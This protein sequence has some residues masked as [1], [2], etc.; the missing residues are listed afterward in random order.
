[1][2][3]LCSLI[4][5]VTVI[6]LSPLVE[7]DS[8]APVV[9][10]LEVA[11][12]KDH[13]E[14]T[15]HGP[16][17]IPD[18]TIK[19]P[20]NGRT[21]VIEVLGA[22]LAEGGVDVKGTSKLINS[23]TASTTGRGVRVE[24]KL[25]YDAVYRARSESGKIRVYFDRFKEGRKSVART[26]I[27]SSSKRPLTVNRV[28]IERRNGQ[29]RIV[30]E[31]NR[32]APFRVVPGDNGPAQISIRGAHL[33]PRV[34][35]K[36]QGG[37]RSA[38]GTVTI[39][40]DTDR[41]LIQ[42]ERDSGI[43]ATAIR[44]GNRIVWLFSPKLGYDKNR[45][46]SQVIAREETVEIDGDQVAAFLSDF[47]M[48]IG[49]V[50]GKKRFTGRR[51]DLDFKDADIHN[52][53]RLMSEIGNV[54]IV[55]SDDVSGSIT[56][57][58]R[59]VPWDQAL[60]VVL[61]AKGL[62][63]VR[64]ENLI[65]VAPLDKLEKERE[66][67]IARKKQ[68]IE[69]APLETR[70]IPVSYADASELSA[71]AKEMLSN[72]G[73][74]SVDSR[75]NILI[76]RDVSESLNDIEELVR[77]LDSQTP[78][79]LIEARIVEATT[80]FNRDIGIQWGG[81]V[82]MSGPTGNPTGLVFPYDMSIAGG[83]YSPDSPTAGMSPFASRVAVPNFAVDLP[84]AVG[85]G[86]GGAIGLSLG[87]IGGNVNL[88]VR[89]SAAES[90]GYIR[91]I[92]SPRILTLDNSSAQIS[93]GTMIPYSQVSAQGVATA[94]REA[95]LMLDVK[96][97]VTS[98]GGVFMEV[99]IN[100]DEPDFTRT[101]ARG[102][103]TILKREASTNLLVQDNHTA[104]IGGIYTRNAGQNTNQVPFFGDI[105]IIGI[106][107]RENKERDERNELLIFLTPRIVNRDEALLR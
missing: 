63:M 79:V 90:S 104:V 100:R 82:T 91:I 13:A 54:N 19:S 26:K 28:N 17:K 36:L 10:R 81:D 76:I 38:V 29:E 30:V 102:D 7:A 14:V 21:V 27:R 60:D 84:A 52:I 34:P 6:A 73:T 61:R 78:Q 2:R 72:R 35:E 96:P 105:P 93:Q 74:V 71:R 47:P 69:L 89:L 99:K 3:I 50:R 11:G 20:D 107:F 95:K 55:T 18:Y 24:I 101:S 65:R 83:A 33:N 41:V 5:A 67:A 22:V 44:E 66:M 86:V 68:Q 85:T 16:F 106:L 59:N 103:P 1:M 39:K 42:A 40:Q 88:N 4:A 43:S 62:G 46:L 37:K 48:Q 9:A 8:T 31:M 32:Q 77:S 64:R 49:S 51:I 92:S 94:F 23:S 58:M 57:R 70:L 12:K 15:I 98:D 45:P 97:H 75:T 87:S 56:I 25:G 80:Q 53:L